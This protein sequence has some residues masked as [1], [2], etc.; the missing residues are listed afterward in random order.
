MISTKTK[1]T[2]TKKGLFGAYDSRRLESTMTGTAWQQVADMITKTAG[3]S[4]H[5]KTQTGNK[6][7]ELEMAQGFKLTKPVCSDILLNQGLIS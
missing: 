6:E 1:V 5:L 3:D 7:S 2:Y 4:S